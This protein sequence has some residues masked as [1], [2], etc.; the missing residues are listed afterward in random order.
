[1]LQTEFAFLPFDIY[2]TIARSA[3]RRIW[4]EI[5]KCSLQTRFVFE[6]FRRL[7]PGMTV[8][9]LHGAMNQLKRV[10]VYDEFCRKQNALLF[11]TDIAARG[12]GK[13]K[14]RKVGGKRYEARSRGR[15]SPAHLGK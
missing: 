2:G 15:S 12:L 14:K 10:A 8:L 13:W 4:A 5:K 7:R 6:V 3:L 1:M 9:A 11:A